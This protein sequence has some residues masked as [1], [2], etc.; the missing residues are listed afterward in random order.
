VFDAVR[1]LD[2]RVQKLPR[3]CECQYED[4]ITGW[5]PN[6]PEGPQQLEWFDPPIR[7][8]R[9]MFIVDRRCIKD[10]PSSI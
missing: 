1:E 2:S 9:S 3:T 6:E 10:V 4:Y 7:Q 5:L 8:D